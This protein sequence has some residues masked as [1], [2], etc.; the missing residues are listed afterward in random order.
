M[1]D[2]IIQLRRQNKRA[3]VGFSLI[4]RRL[5]NATTEP[6]TSPEVIPFKV[7][8][9]PVAKPPEVKSRAESNRN[10]RNNHSRKGSLRDEIKRLRKLHDDA[11]SN[12]RTT[13]ANF[14]ECDV[15][16]AGK[17][18]EEQVEQVTKSIAASLKTQKDDKHQ[19]DLI[20]MVEDMKQV[21][22]NEREVVVAMNENL[23]ETCYADREDLSPLCALPRIEE[24]KES[25][26]Q[27]ENIESIVY[28]L[29]T[30]YGFE[31]FKKIYQVIKNTEEKQNGELMI[32]EYLAKLRGIVKKEK[33]LKDLYLFISL[34]RTEEQA[35]I[36]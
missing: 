22:N 15:L 36:Y 10:C 35:Y 24:K 8:A 27:F 28:H 12:G 26:S 32:K 33:I 5:S 18:V 14:A 6:E 29:E 3:G 17:K 34:K 2:E 31:N 19:E 7:A 1:R 9:Q 4:Q 21:L 25:V 11:K 16:V 13:L 30:E 20:S 23:S